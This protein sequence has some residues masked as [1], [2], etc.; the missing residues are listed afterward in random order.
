[1]SWRSNKSNKYNRAEE[2]EYWL[3]LV[4]DQEDSYWYPWGCWWDDDAWWDDYWYDDG[5]QSMEQ[6]AQFRLLT[7]LR[8]L[9]LRSARQETEDRGW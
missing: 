4:D 6:L 5:I 8:L 2:T 7:L 9:S 3:Q 1:M